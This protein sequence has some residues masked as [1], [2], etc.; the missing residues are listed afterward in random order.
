MGRKKERTVQ[1]LFNCGDSS[2]TSGFTERD[3]IIKCTE[4]FEQYD[5][6]GILYEQYGQCN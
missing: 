4:L 6:G 1:K 2:N 3:F 5:C